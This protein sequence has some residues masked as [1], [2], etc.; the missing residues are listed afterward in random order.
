MVIIISREGC[1]LCEQ[2]KRTMK[3]QHIAYIEY[4]IGENITREEVLESYPGRKS[5]PILVDKNNELVE[6]SSLKQYL[7]TE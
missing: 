5:L 6:I 7:W 3:L 1:V 4:K 2:A